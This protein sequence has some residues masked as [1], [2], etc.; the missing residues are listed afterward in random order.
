MRAKKLVPMKEISS[1]INK[2][3]LRHVRSKR[4]AASPVSSF[5]HDWPGAIWK[6]VHEVLAP[7][8]MLNAAMPVYAVS[9]TVAHMF[10][11]W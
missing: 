5:F 1:T 9:S 6:L 3:A 2:T 10:L 4:R 7:K 8:P 11:S